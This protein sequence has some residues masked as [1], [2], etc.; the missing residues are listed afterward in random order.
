M[1]RVW[2]IIRIGISSRLALID[3]KIYITKALCSSNSHLYAFN[4]AC[5]NW[6]SATPKCASANNNLLCSV[7]T[8]LPLLSVMSFKLW[9]VI[10]TTS[11]LPFKSTASLVPSTWRLW[12]HA[13]S[14]AFFSSPLQALVKGT[15]PWPKPLFKLS[16]LGEPSPTPNLK[17]PHQRSSYKTIGAHSIT[18][19]FP[20]SWTRVHLIAN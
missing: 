8:S 10:S 15:R 4:S 5:Q 20:L 7:M 9:M 17:I 12:A 6:V 16:Q 11:S 18:I 13:L 1:S 2:E 19:Y 3:G 14:T